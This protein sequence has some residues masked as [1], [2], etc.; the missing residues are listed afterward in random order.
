MQEMV[1]GSD[2]VQCSGGMQCLCKMQCMSM[3]L[4]VLGR[5]IKNLMIRCRDSLSLSGYGEGMGVS[6]PL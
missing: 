1:Q 6:L 5:Q 4:V 3:R 2:R